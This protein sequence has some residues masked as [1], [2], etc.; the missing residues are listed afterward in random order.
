MTTATDEDVIRLGRQVHDLALATASGFME[1]KA[2]DEAQDADIAHITA[3]LQLID[4]KIVALNARITDLR[5]DC[6]VGWDRQ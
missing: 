3:R 2:I 6:E 5:R 4:D 1:V